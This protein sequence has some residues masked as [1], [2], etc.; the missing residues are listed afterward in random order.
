MKL[1]DIKERE[2]CAAINY[3]CVTCKGRAFYTT[4]YNRRIIVIHEDGCSFQRYIFL[5]FPIL[6]RRIREIMGSVSS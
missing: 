5:R 4:G 2:D 3:A 6:A 1:Q